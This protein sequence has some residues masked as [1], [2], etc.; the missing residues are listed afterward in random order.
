MF[1]I[2]DIKESK[3]SLMYYAN[4]LS[5]FMGQQGYHIYLKMLQL[6]VFVLV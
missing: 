3:G 4:A 5:T 6:H 2:S 1:Q